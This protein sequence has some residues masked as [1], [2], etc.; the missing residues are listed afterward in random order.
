MILVWSFLI[1]TLV[2]TLSASYF[3]YFNSEKI[4]REQISNNLLHSSQLIENSIE[5]FLSEQK[6]KIELIATQDELSN[7]EL[8]RISKI[9][10]SFYEIFVIN[11]SGIIVASSDVTHVGVDR[12]NDSY[13]VNAI[14]QTYIKPVYFSD[15]T[16]GYSFTISTPFHNSVLV[17]RIDISHFD[18][19]LSD[20]TGLGK[21]GE[22]LMAFVNKDGEVVYFT[23]RLFSDKIIETIPYAQLPMPMKNALEDNEILSWD[24]KDYRG[25]N[26]IAASNYIDSMRI[27]MVTKRDYSEAIGIVRD[28]LRRLSIIVASIAVFI[29]FIISWIIAYRISRSVYKLREGVDKIIKGDLS[30]QLDKSDIFEVQSLTDSLN[31]ILATMKLVI[32]RTGLSKGNIGIGEAVMAKEEAETKYKLI[33][34]T[35]IDA[36][37]ILESPKWNF[38]SGNPAAIKMFNVKDEEQLATLTPAD[39]S[40]KMQPDGHLSGLKVKKMIEK[41]L[42]EGRAFFEWTHKRYNGE[43]FLANVLLSRFEENGKTYIQATVREIN[44]EGAHSSVRKK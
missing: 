20:K 27:G 24:T 11:S 37:M 23:K 4:L 15:F 3:G 31:R 9:D 10:D 17:I 43:N 32:L 39:L 1:V 42:K 25:V 13:F 22:T 14:S 38:S 30:I 35:S 34:E 6:N 16:E 8:F 7:E 5:V 2:G 33:Y 26:V 40:P 19:L 18:R 36:R 12:H 29:V 41:A 21:T 28:R 44:K